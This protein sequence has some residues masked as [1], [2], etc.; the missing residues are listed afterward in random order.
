MAGRRKPYCRG[1]CTALHL[2]HASGVELSI[3]NIGNIM[4]LF[5]IRGNTFTATVCE[6]VS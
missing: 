5:G 2:G 4:Y 6:I 1:Y 3:I